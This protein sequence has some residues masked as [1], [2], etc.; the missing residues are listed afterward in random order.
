MKK[1]CICLLLLIVLGSANGMN[2]LPKVS[3]TTQLVETPM[4]YDPVE[5]VYTGTSSTPPWLQL[6]P[7]WD[8][9][10]RINDIYNRND[11]WLSMAVDAT[12]RIYVA[13]QSPWSPTAALY[14]SGVASSTDQG[15]TWDNRVFYVNNVNRNMQHPDIAISANGKINLW[16]EYFRIDAGQN[17]VPGFM[18]SR[19]T[20]YNN[21]DSLFGVTYF[22]IPNRKYPDV[23]ALG[24]GNQFTG[25]QWTVDQT[26]TANDSIWIIFTQDSVGYYAIAFQVAAGYPG[27]TSFTVDAL[28]IDTIWVHGIE[29]FDVANNDWD[30]ACYFDTL[31]SGSLYGWTTTNTLDDRY[32]SL[33]S[34][35]GYSYI[36]FQSDIGSGNFEVMFNNST[37]Y[38]GTWGGTIQNLSNDGAPDMYPRLHGYGSIIGVDYFHGYNQVFFNYSILNGQ[39]GTWLGTPEILTDAASADT[40]IHACAL[41]YTPQYYYATWEDARNM[42]TDSIE[43]YACR[44]TAP[45]GIHENSSAL[46]NNPLRALPNPFANST[47]IRFNLDQ[48]TRVDLSIYD[49]S[50]RI[51]R[52][53]IRT[54]AQAGDYSFTWDRKDYRGQTVPSGVYFGR[55][56]TNRGTMTTNLILLK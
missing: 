37:D 16:F 50:G 56:V 39:T 19:A 33:F 38:G 1:I 45:I 36:S 21:P 7:P 35:Q 44:R 43:V 6:D 48:P 29:Y 12:G 3:T 9:G 20:C 32:P 13:Y 28:G 26:G 52:N 34:D 10:V 22:A 25:I 54:R 15:L 11:Q 18:R 23:V 5:C 8:P 24:N 14:G 51:V 40:G 31:G 49:A 53:L 42:A 46:N 47:T 41:L 17:F 55:L 30:I 4:G 2:A 27:V